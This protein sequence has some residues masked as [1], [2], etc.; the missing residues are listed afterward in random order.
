MKKLEIIIESVEVDKIIKI[1]NKHNVKG[2]T[3]IDNAA[4]RGRHGKISSSDLTG[5]LKSTLLIIADENDILQ[6]V[7]AEVNPILDDYSG[8][9][10][11]SDIQIFDGKSL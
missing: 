7:I 5:F 8:I 10:L 11:L 9:M 1:L 2:Y 3:R 6:K 4:G